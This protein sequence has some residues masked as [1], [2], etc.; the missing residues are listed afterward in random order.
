MIK[1]VLKELK[2]FSIMVFWWMDFAR[3]MKMAEKFFSVWGFICATYEI[4][5]IALSTTIV[6]DILRNN[7]LMI[8]IGSAIYA[9][10]STKKVLNYTA[11]IKDTG[12]KVS[13]SIGSLFWAKANSF[14]ISTNTTFDTRMDNEFISETSVQGQFQLKYFKNNLQSLDKLL[15]EGLEG[16]LPIHLNRKVSKCDQYPVGTVSKVNYKK[17][18]YYFTAIADINEKGKTVNTS[19]ENVKKCLLG[20]W[21]FISQ[22]GHVEDLAIPVIGTGRA[23]IP[24]LSIEKAIMEMIYSI[25]DYSRTKKISNHFYIRIHPSD[26]KKN[27]IDMGELNVFLQCMCNYRQEII[28]EHRV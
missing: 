7:F 16:V 2:D 28:E 17:K 23:G 1:D 6:K 19:V 10:I 15:D 25:V 24:N 27:S 11:T 18:H 8:L 5:D 12:I 3:F 22:K 21:E 13:L 9:F 26:I 4:E 14:V 20:T